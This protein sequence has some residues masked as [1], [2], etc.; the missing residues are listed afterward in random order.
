MLDALPDQVTPKL[1]GEANGRERT[2][3]PEGFARLE[4]DSG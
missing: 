4:S 1:P 3:G 2:G